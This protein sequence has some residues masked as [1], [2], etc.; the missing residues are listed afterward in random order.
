[1]KGFSFTFMLE[2]LKIKL[3]GQQPTARITSKT[4]EGIIQRDFGDRA[5]EVMRKLD[6]L[7][8]DSQLGKNRRAAAILKLANK[9]IEAIDHF[10]AVGNEDFRDVIVPAEYPRC[11]ELG[12]ARFPSGWVERRRIY[13]EDWRQYIEWL[14]M[15]NPNDRKKT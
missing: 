3:L 2:T 8:G 14:R 15:P 12:F 4:L 9:D 11:H 7:E 1:M 5:E 6:M 10:I 13:L